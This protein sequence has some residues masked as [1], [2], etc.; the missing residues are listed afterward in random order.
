[1]TRDGCRSYSIPFDQEKAM[2]TQLILTIATFVIAS[3]VAAQVRFYHHRSTAFGDYA[4]GMAELELARGRAAVDRA[5]AY[6]CRLCA[7]R[8]R[9]YLIYDRLEARQLAQESRQQRSQIAADARAKRAAWR[10]ARIEAA[11]NELVADLDAGT[12]KWPRLLA[13]PSFAAERVQIGQLLQVRRDVG[14]SQLPS[15][16]EVIG[17]LR[18]KIL[19]SQANATHLERVQAMRVVTQLEYLSAAT[20]EQRKVAKR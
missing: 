2:K 15:L 1:M 7:E 12:Y 17:Q 10:Q 20:G 18:G 5:N 4:A 6:E 19:D 13:G 11:A 8:Q 14:D 9:Q 16:I 3:P